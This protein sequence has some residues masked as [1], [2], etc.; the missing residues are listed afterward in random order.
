MAQGEQ[1]KRGIPTGIS[2]RARNCRTARRKKAGRRGERVEVWEEELAAREWELT[3]ARVR[4]QAWK[5]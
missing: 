5:A 4:E 1:R 3:G 2:G